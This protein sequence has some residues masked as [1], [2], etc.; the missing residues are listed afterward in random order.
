MTSLL[1]KYIHFTKEDTVHA[2]LGVI[3]AFLFVAFGHL[4]VGVA[5]ALG[6][7]PTSLLGFAPQ[8]RMR[9][10]FGI[11]GCLFGL[12]I[13]LG[14]LI[15]DTH[16]I[17]ETSVLFVVICFVATVLAAKRPAGGVLLNTLIPSLGIGT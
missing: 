2:A 15:I 11:V 3:P 4:T 1:Q 6:L 14:A 10:V 7:L 8:R 9:I 5:F 12:G 13:F 16:N 17:V